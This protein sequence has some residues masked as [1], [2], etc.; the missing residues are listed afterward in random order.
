MT[1]LDPIPPGP[2]EPLNPAALNPAPADPAAANSAAADWDRTVHWSVRGESSAKIFLAD[3]SNIHDA[4]AQLPIWMLM[5]ASAAVVT[6]GQLVLPRLGLRPWASWTIS[7]VLAAA[8]MLLGLRFVKGWGPAR[9]TFGAPNIESDARFRVRAFGGAKALGPV[10]AAFDPGRD[11]GFDPAVYFAFFAVAPRK[12]VF[13]WF[14]LG[15]TALWL[16]WFWWQMSSGFRT[17]IASLEMMGIAGGMAILWAACFPVYFRVSPGRLEVMRA[18]FLGRSFAVSESHDLRALRLTIDA[19]AR[20]IY[21]TRSAP[22]GETTG[23]ELPV[24][25]F[26]YRNVPRGT[27]FA[28]MLLSAATCS[29]EAPD[30]P[31][32]RL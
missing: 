27:E 21:L 5:G 16:A 23:A 10:H 26:S 28:A 8:L 30:L 7:G 24:S 12:R 20:A 13:V 29:A 18:G 22:D 4:M 17:H 31:K 1:C 25:L 11:S 2:L 32:D 14:W 9:G 15:V 3:K 6:T 19:G